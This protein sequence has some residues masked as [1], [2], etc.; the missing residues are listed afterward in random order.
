VHSRAHGGQGF[1]QGRVRIV[2][3]SEGWVNRDCEE[4]SG[5]CLGQRRVCWGVS[6]C[7]MQSWQWGLCTSPCFSTVIVTQARVT[8]VAACI[9]AVWEE[10]FLL[11]YALRW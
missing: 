7:R 8:N 2:L 9:L 3:R 6:C 5:A 1:V 11:F 10:D 4:H